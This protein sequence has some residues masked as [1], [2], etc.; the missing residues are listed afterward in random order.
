MQLWAFGTLKC[1]LGLTERQLWG[2]TRRKL[3][4]LVKV[5]QDEQYRLDLRSALI[6]LD[7]RNMWGVGKGHPDPWQLDEVLPRHGVAVS[8]SGSI[9]SIWRRI[10][11]EAT[12]AQRMQF[13]AMKIKFSMAEKMGLGVLGEEVWPLPS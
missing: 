12:D 2:L 13:Q 6:R 11:P 3:N 7:M 9:E 5:Y 10:R 4:A 8:E 1:G